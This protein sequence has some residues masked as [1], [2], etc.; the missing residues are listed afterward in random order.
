MPVLSCSNGKWR[1]G[2]GKCMYD[3]KEKAEAAYKGYLGAKYGEEVFGVLE[4][5]EKKSPRMAI[6]IR[7]FLERQA[8]KEIP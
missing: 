2:K 3:S 6:R 4:K 5:I 8:N 7:T 1:I